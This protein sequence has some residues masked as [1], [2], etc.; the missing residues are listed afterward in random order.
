[1]STTTIDDQL[2]DIRRRTDR[3]EVGARAGASRTWR[4][5]EALREAESAVYAALRERAPDEA[6]HRL[7]ELKA[8]LDIAERA[9]EADAAGDWTAFAAAVEAE[10]DGWDGYLERLQAGAAARAWKAREQAEQTIGELR[11]RRIAV[12][13]R[14]ARAHSTGG[15]ASAARKHVT[16]AR[17]ELDKRAASLFTTLNGKE[18]Q[19]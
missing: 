17:N 19:K 3:L 5:L 10:L 16:A 15:T 1:M 13:E 12:G 14:L 18:W 11:G 6:E 4:H 7:S 8:R 9:L 2:A